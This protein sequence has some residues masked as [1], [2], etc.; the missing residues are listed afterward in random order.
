MTVPSYILVMPMLLL[1]ILTSTVQS[2]TGSNDT[3]Q[4][5]VARP[6]AGWHMEVHNHKLMIVVIY[7][8]F[9]LRKRDKQTVNIKLPDRQNHNSASFHVICFH[10]ISYIVDWFINVCTVRIVICSTLFIKWLHNMRYWS[11]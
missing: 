10:F 1:F 9:I 5:F 2:W 11:P 6:A 4:G 7:Y 3:T 8:V